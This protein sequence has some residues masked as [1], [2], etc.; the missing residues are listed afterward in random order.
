MGVPTHRLPSVP[1]AILRK[2]K[3]D[4]EERAEQA[5]QMATKKVDDEKKNVEYFKRAEQ[6]V[7][8]Y[9]AE[10]LDQQRLAREAKLA[11][12]F[13]VPGEPK[14]AFVMRIRG[15]NQVAPKVRKVLQLF[16]LRQINNG[17]FIR[18]NKAT[19]NM[20][21]ICEPYVTWGT[22]SLENI[23]KLVYKRGCLKIKGQR[24]PITSNELIEGVLGKHNIICTEDLIHEIYTVGPNFKYA[25]NAVWPF[26]L[27]NPRGGWK[28]KTNHFVEGGDFG[29]REDMINILLSKMI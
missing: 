12:D 8:E 5:K 14:L 22:P 20:L 28:K 3:R 15:I 2:R 13:Y 11:G 27:Q 17:V 21:R 6:Y 26:K 4:A 19:I 10:E 1:E 25:S 23:R 29:C 16:R 9:R 24:I 7:K 18:L